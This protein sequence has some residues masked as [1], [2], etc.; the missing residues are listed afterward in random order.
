MIGAN[1]SSSNPSNLQGGWPSGWHLPSDAE[2][3]EFADYLGGSSVAGGKL[4]EPGTTHWNSPNTGATNESGF[5][6]LPGGS[7]SSGGT[8]YSMGEL[9]L[10]LS[11]TP[12]CRFSF[13]HFLRSNMSSQFL[14]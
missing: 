8:F 3:T 14:S 13:S 1:S 12:F 11:A 2:W 6:A 9:T 7:R 10:F 5:M 4:K